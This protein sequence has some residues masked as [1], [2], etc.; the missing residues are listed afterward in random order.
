MVVGLVWV[1]PNLVILGAHLTARITMGGAEAYVG[2]EKFAAVDAHVWRGAAPSLEG[3]RRLAEDGVTTVVELRA[4]APSTLEADVAPFGLTVERIPIRDGQ[5]ATPA[6]IDRFA[7]IVAD[8][9]GIVFV[10]CGAGVGRTGVMAGAHLSA[11]GE[12]GSRAVAENLAMGTPS[13]EQLYAVASMDD[14]QRGHVPGA[15]TVASRIVDGPRRLLH[16]LG[17]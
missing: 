3:Y 5:S 10:H 4:E 13:L 14:G 16:V 2:V 12:S 1:V 15:I 7:S 11:S 6:Q 17:L 8:A 9:P